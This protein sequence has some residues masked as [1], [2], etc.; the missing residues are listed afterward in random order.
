MANTAEI[1]SPLS[2]TDLAGRRA[3]FFRAN[4]QGEVD[5]F[6]LEI[7]TEEYLKITTMAPDPQRRGYAAMISD[8]MASLRLSGK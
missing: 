3:W 2:Q 5:Y 8:I 6:Y 4:D 7:G 1:S